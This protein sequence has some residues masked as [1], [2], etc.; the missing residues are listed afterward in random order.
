MGLNPT[1][2]ENGLAIAAGTSAFHWV[3]SS[4]TGLKAALAEL[5]QVHEKESDAAFDKI[6]ALE[7]KVG[8]VA[9]DALKI[10]GLAVSTQAMQ[11]AL[12]VLRILVVS[13]ANSKKQGTS[14]LS[15]LQSP[16]FQAA[17][18]TAFA[19]LPMIPVEAAN[20]SVLDDLALAKALYSTATDIAAALKGLPTSPIVPVT[21]PNAAGPK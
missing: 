17:A 18:A 4:I 9:T 11:D 12:S 7:N 13:V 16:D 3:W 21:V 8:P 5:A 19:E 6:R 2:I 20:L 1:D 14:L 15:F 10:G